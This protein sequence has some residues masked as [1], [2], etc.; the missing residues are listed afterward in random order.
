[1]NDGHL[2]E[3]TCVKL[4]FSFVLLLE[5]LDKLILKETTAEILVVVFEVN[6]EVRVPWINSLKIN[7]IKPSVCPY[8]AFD[9]RRSCNFNNL[10]CLLLLE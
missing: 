5:V 9:L 10:S 1:M 2:S 3:K 6:F 7:K 4:Y 8:Q